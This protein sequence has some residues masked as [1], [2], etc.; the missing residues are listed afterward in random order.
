MPGVLKKTKSS[1]PKAGP[2]SMKKVGNAKVGKAP[3]AK[4]KY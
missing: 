1:A 3:K 4:K 2:K